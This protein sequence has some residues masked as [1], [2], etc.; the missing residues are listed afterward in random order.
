MVVGA[1]NFED[2][3][4]T[5]GSILHIKKL[6]DVAEIVKTMKYLDENPSAYNETLR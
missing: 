1:P 4:P 3:V 6:S 2:F 5:P